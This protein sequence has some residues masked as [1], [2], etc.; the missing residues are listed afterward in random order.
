LPGNQSLDLHTGWYVQYIN[1]IQFQDQESLNEFYYPA[2]KLETRTVKPTTSLLLSAGW[3]AEKMRDEWDLS[4][5]AYYK[6]LNRITVFAPNELPDSLKNRFAELRLGEMFKEAEGYSYGFELSLRR[7]EGLLFGGLSYSYGTA[8]IKEDG[9]DTAY[10]PKWHQ[11]HSVKA[12]LAINWRGKDGLWPG[13]KPGRY[14]RS[15][16]QVKYASGLPYTSEIGYLPSHLQEESPGRPAGGPVPEFQDNV[17][18]I[19]G[20]RNSAFVPAYFRWDAKVVDWG[21]EGKW[22]FAFTLV[23]ITNHENVFLYTYNRKNN[24]PTRETITQFPFFPLLVNYE[25]YF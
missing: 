1:S 17:N 13:S 10:F 18:T 20:S 22:N 25:Y 19:K 6:T 5:E 8:V 14:F 23:N 12:D 3:S 9:T 24:P 16:T 21:R 4:V 11:P 15:S 7:P 2:Q